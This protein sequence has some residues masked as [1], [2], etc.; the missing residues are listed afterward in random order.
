MRCFSEA[1]TSGKYNR[2]LQNA[3]KFVTDLQFGAT[4]S[5]DAPWNG[6]VGYSGT[7]HPDLS[8]TSSCIETLRSTEEG[9]D[10]EA[11]QHAMVFVSRCQNLASEGNDTEFAA[12]VGDGGL[13]CA[14]P[15]EKVD[16]STSPARYTVNG[17]PRS[18]GSMTYAGLR[19]M[20]YA[21]LTPDAPRVK[22]AVQWIK[23]HYDVTTNPGTG[24]GGHYHSHH[25]FAASLNQANGD[26]ITTEDGRNHPWRLELIAHLGATQNADGSWSNRYARWFEDDKNQATSFALL[27]LAHC[28]PAQREGDK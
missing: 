7:D 3:I 25:T 19:S 8:N 20:V 16:A 28:R 2:I 9:S 11:F 24:D 14:I 5:P 27:A 4:G 15:K 6:G 21:G 22:A 10:S 26:S 12:L 1:N 23:N 17:G 18:D 13:Y